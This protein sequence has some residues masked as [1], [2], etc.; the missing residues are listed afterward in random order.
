M[1][2]LGVFPSG[3][4][5]LL[6]A[7]MREQARDLLLGIGQSRFEAAQAVFGVG[8]PFLCGHQ[9]GVYLGLGAGREVDRRVESAQSLSGPVD[10]GPSLR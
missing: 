8:H 6:L 9:A 7:A 3:G 2:L 5:F 10:I 4:E 1:N